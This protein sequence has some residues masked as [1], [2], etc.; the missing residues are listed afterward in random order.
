M[1]LRYVYCVQTR[2]QLIESIKSIFTIC[3]LGIASITTLTVLAYDRYLMIRYPFSSTRLTKET[4]LYAIAGIW[5]YAFAVTGPPLFGWN[6]YV[7]ESANIRW[8]P[9]TGRYTRFTIYVCFLVYNRCRSEYN[10]IM[11]VMRNKPLLWWEFVCVYDDPAECFCGRP[12]CKLF[13]HWG[14]TTMR[15]LARTL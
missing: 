1:T 12:P 14:K 7:N 10:K 4:A 8:G 5:M 11:L 13:P 2:F 6:H 15:D 3:W 9:L